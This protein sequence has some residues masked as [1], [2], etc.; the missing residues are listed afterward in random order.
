M[1]LLL[2]RLNGYEKRRINFENY[3]L[4]SCLWNLM[5]LSEE[6]AYKLLDRLTSGW[7]LDLGIN[8]LDISATEYPEEYKSYTSV[9]QEPDGLKR[10]RNEYSEQQVQGMQPENDTI[11]S[12]FTSEVDY[13]RYCIEEI[14]KSKSYKIGLALTWLPRKIRGW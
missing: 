11:Q 2:L 14:R 4:H 13:L 8:E 5:T 3:A 10:C 9:L 1:E 6:N 12:Q 7:N